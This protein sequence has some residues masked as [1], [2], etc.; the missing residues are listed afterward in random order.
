MSSDSAGAKVK[1]SPKT[2]SKSNASA[3]QKNAKKGVLY[4]VATPIGNLADMVPRA[5]ETLQQVDCIACEDTRHSRRLLD[6]YHI[7][8]TL[9]PFH[10]HN[11]D[12]MVP[13]LIERLSEGESIALISDAGT[14][15]VSDPGYPLI[16]AAHQHGITVSPIPGPSAAIT[17]L[18][19]SGLPTNRFQFE[20]FLP[21]KTTAR[22]KT[23]KE[24]VKCEATMVFYEAP[25]RIVDCLQSMADIFGSEREGVLARELTKTHET[26]RFGQLGNLLEFVQADPNQQKGEIVILVRGADNSRKHEFNEEAARVATLLKDHMPPKQAAAITEAIVGINKKSIYQFLINEDHNK[27]V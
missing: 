13:T 17:A 12:T 10:E 1:T 9:L 18:S 19:A 5:V 4:V 8:T 23:L 11:E 14:P 3:T 22:N 26:I 16:R 27:E 24:L 21:A 15:L 2:A 25:H 20:G 6:H 7:S